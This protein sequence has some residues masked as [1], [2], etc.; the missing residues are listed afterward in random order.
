MGL[1]SSAAYRAKHHEF[2][3]VYQVR[4][5]VHA[6]ALKIPERSQPLEVPMRPAS[7]FVFILLFSP[8]VAAQ[9]PPRDPQAVAILQRALAAMG[10]PAPTD[11][12][13]TGTAVLVAGS[14]TETG[15]IRILTRRLDQSAEYFQ[16]PAESRVVIY[17]RGH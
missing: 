3:R 2:C 6:F 14:T 17:S 10:R 5:V 1:Y 4:T 7:L 15:T 11:S 9:Q 16:T 8:S 12:V 13:A